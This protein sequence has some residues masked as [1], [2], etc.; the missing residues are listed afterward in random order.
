MYLNGNISAQQTDIHPPSC[1]NPNTVTV[2]CGQADRSALNSVPALLHHVVV[3]D[4]ASI[5]RA[6][7]HRAVNCF[8]CVCVC[9]YICIY[10]ERES[11]ILK[12]NGGQ[13]GDWCLI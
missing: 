10:I 7:L 9:I 2:L 12:R 4:H 6:E 11:I 8:V 3:G 5:Y 1:W 13:N